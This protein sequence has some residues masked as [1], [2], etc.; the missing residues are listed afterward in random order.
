MKKKSTNITQQRI[1]DQ[2]K[3][4]MWKARLEVTRHD[5][6]DIHRAIGAGVM[7]ICRILM[8]D[9][10]ERKKK[11]ADVKPAATPDSSTTLKDET[12]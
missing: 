6:D 2:E 11:L 7:A 10:A 3:K 8:K 9:V 1:T 4:E 5:R 12:P